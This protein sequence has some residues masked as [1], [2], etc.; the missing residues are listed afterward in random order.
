MK[1]NPV[2]FTKYS[3]RL[4]LPFIDDKTTTEEIL[5]FNDNSILNWMIIG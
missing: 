3:P 2:I 4:M 1:E 5:A